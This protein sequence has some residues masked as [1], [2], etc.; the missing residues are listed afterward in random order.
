MIGSQLIY[1]N[2]TI[3]DWVEVAWSEGVP[4]PTAIR[5]AA[6]NIR[7]GMKDLGGEPSS[8]YSQVA[9]YR[10][11]NPGDG[12]SGSV[13]IKVESNPVSAGT[14]SSNVKNLEKASAAL[15]SQTKG[16]EEQSS[17]SQDTGGKPSAE[18]T[19][20]QERLGATNHDS[21][22]VQSGTEEPVVSSGT[23]VDNGRQTADA[24]KISVT[25]KTLEEDENTIGT[26]EET[27]DS[28]STSKDSA[29][30]SESISTPSSLQGSKTSENTSET[31]VTIGG[32]EALLESVRDRNTTEPSTSDV[33]MPTTS[34]TGT[35]TS[36][37]NQ[38]ELLTPGAVAMTSL[39]EAGIKT[40]LQDQTKLLTSDD[41]SSEVVISQADKPS[42][43][44]YTLTR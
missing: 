33:T 6:M 44:I 17:T 14:L 11:K 26:K 42:G 29:S 7:A 31:L 9:K 41:K 43:M 15:D 5:N 20:K 30:M 1:F 3:S 16:S 36:S 39:L 28:S 8:L 27:P 12:G 2:I 40:S 13:S 35:N 18:S 22:E 23:Q 37:Q 21:D 32:Y 34:E 25:T 10:F 38:T 19:G 4:L 24:I